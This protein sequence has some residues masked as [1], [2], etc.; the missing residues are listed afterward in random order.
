MSIYKRTQL[1]IGEEI[2]LYSLFCC[3]LALDELTMDTSSIESFWKNNK[4]KRF[5]SESL[6]TLS[7]EFL[8]ERLI[9]PISN[10][11]YHD[12]NNDRSDENQSQPVQ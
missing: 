7:N 9:S 5:S 3:C 11:S 10:Y 12:Q 2:D 8:S 4:Q 1:H 6:I